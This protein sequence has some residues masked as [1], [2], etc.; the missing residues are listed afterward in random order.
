MTFRFVRMLLGTLCVAS[1]V[2]AATDLIPVS[3]FARRMPLT[4]PRLS[5]NGQYLS[6]A[7][8]D[9]DGKT[10]GLANY[11]V[12]DM[13]KAMTLITMPPYEMPADM[14]WA[15]STRL[16]VARGKVDGS[17]G[18][19]SYTGELMAIDVDGKHL[20]YLY[21]YEKVGK[22]AATR[23]LDRGWGT[24]EGAPVPSNGHFYLRATGWT[25]QTHSILYDVDA[26]TSTRKPLAEIGLGNMSFLIGPDGSPRFAFGW[27]DAAQWAVFHREGSGW[28]KLATG[29]CQAFEPL[30]SVVSH[31][32]RI[33]AHF[34]PDGK[35]GALVEQD[36]NGANLRVI[37]QDDFSEV[38]ADGL[39]T[40]VPRRPFG[41]IAATGIPSVIYVD[42]Q[43]SIAKLHRALAQ[44]FPGSFVSFIDFSEDGGQLLFKVASDREPGRYMLIDTKTY[45]VS[46]LFD[47]QPW[48]DPSKMAER[49]PL[50]FTASDGT[51][52]EAILTFPV[53]KAETDL[54]MVLVPHGGP[55]GIA[56]DWF[57][58]TDA[59]FLANRGYLV[60]QVNYRGSGG[61]GS[62]FENAGHLKWGSRIQEDLIDGVKWAIAQRYADP[63][64]ICVY[65]GS[66]G[67]YSALMTTIR[68]PGLF[69]CAVG[70]AGVYDLDMMYNKGDIKNHKAGRSYLATVIGKDPADLAAN[71]PTHLADRIEV[72]VFLVHGEADERAPFAQFKA[73]RS[74]LDAAHRPY[75]TLTKP[76]ERHGFVK[77]ANIEEF[78]TRLQAFLDK[79]IG[80]G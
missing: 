17:I 36:E 14:I 41:T 6:V 66:F 77:P 32:E 3:D 53:G 50:R 52:L 12:S 9:P 33:Y 58:D 38:S 39:W 75:E 22:R 16:V 13:S 62:A 5:P 48:M 46:K 27:D 76:G 57:Y 71:S 47:T 45:K 61:R 55:H 44:K 15:S 56:N 30:A 2:A 69:Q 64:R 42:P 59:Q 74:A 35:G 20:D 24:I 67:G 23:A 68:A 43:E 51:A 29:T 34:S 54:P 73:M 31:P 60:L 72:P 11:R 70:Y 63:K 4:G 28:G 7:Y 19:A 79:H 21:G 18:D 1:S 78:Y 26:A 80:S 40:A 10:H 65:G 49:R 8:H 37:R 25:D